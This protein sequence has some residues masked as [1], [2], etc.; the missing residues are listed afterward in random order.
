MIIS[1]NKTKCITITREPVRCKL[2]IEDKNMKQVS[3]LKVESSKKPNQYLRTESK[4]KVY[5]IYMTYYD[6]RHRNTR[7]NK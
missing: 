5:K 2:A 1:T 7:R 6:I 4:V 3:Q